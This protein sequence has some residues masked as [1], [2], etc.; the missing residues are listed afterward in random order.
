MLR[1]S[2]LVRATKSRVYG[3]MTEL[4]LPR[5]RRADVRQMAGFDAADVDPTAPVWLVSFHKATTATRQYSS[6]PGAG[7]GKH[8]EAHYGQTGHVAAPHDP[9]GAAAPPA[10]QASGRASS[11]SNALDAD[12]L[13]DASAPRA[14]EPLAKAER[15]L[16]VDHSH[17]P[18]PVAAFRGAARGVSTVLEKDG[19][20][21]V[22]AH[23]PADTR[24]N[25]VLERDSSPHDVEPHR[26]PESRLS[27]DLEASHPHDVEVFHPEP[28]TK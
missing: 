7:G 12:R 1:R 4:A 5:S 25:P 6:A 21:G 3:L 10:K 23:H 18:H 15:S 26:A 22:A 24:V 11:N 28:K 9:V 16:D 8:H 27:A 2:L 20:K 14:V 19:P 13:H 17:D